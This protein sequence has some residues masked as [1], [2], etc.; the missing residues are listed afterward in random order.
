MFRVMHAPLPRRALLGGL[1]ALGLSRAAF[2]QSTPLML[3]NVVLGRDGWLYGGWEDVRRVDLA[4]TRRVTTLISNA[5]SILKQN[6]I[7]T[8]ISLTPTKARIYPE[9]LPEAFRST[10]DAERRYAVALEELRRPGTVVPDLATLFA[11]L[12]RTQPTQPLY[13]KADIHWTPMAAEPAAVETAKAIK[14]GLRLPPSARPGTRLG[15]HVSMRYEKNDLAE[16]LPATERGKYAFENFRVRQVQ[17][18][19]GQA[20]LIEDDS[21]D[22][23]V[24]GNSFMQVGYGF[25]PMLSNQLER[26]VSLAVKIGRVGPYRTLLDYVTSAPFRQSRPKLL[27]WHFLEG[28]MEILPDHVGTW[29]TGAIAPQ[30]FL[31]DLRRAVAAPR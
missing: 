1:G 14:A 19:S 10:A 2:G 26:P 30:D 13:F 23:V 17:R 16:Q 21:A 28:N 9:F 25:P 12:R 29:A 4:R 7:D 24:V 11:D 15:P 20:A 22:V 8:V 31:N 6:G 18:A 5:A 27:V 3:N